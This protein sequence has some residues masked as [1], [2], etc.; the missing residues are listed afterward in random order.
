MKNTVFVCLLALASLL[1]TS[2]KAQSCGNDSIYKLPYK[3]TYVKSTLAADNEFRTMRPTYMEIPTFE[4]AKKILPVPIWAGH[5]KEIE[6]YWKAWEIGVGNI[7]NPQPGSGFVSPYIDT[8]YNGNIFMWD[9]AFILMFARY[10]ERFFPFQK[11]LDNFYAKQHPDGFICREIMANGADCFERYDPTSTGP[12]L[13]PWC[14]MIY[15]HQFGDTERLHKIF[16]ALCGYYEWLRLNR[17]WRNGTYWTSGW[18]TGM[19]NMPRVPSE[20]NPIYSHGHMIWLDANLQQIFN[21]S[22]L[23]ELGFYTE[24]WQ[25]IETLEDEAKMLKKYVRENL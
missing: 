19:D 25:E 10:G 18:G 21:A 9:S 11:T 14:E 5:E 8:A 7:R 2:A 13:L 16:P 12:N 20:Y 6:M 15:Y 17:T 24:R 3:N 1:A 22:L 4:T 23:L